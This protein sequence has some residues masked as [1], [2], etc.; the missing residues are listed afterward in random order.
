MYAIETQKISKQFGKDTIFENIDFRIKE[1]EVISILGPSG[2]GKSTFIRCLANLE[3]I[4][5]GTIKIFDKTLVKDGNYVTTKEQKS[6]LNNVGFVFQELNLFNHLTVE[7]NLKLSPRL[8]KK[9]DCLINQKYKNLLNA[10]GL[11]GKENN[12]PQDLSGGQKQRVAIARALM[13]E[14]SILLFDEPTSALDPK[15]TEETAKIILELASNKKTIIIV[16][17]DIFFSELVSDKTFQIS[18]N[19]FSTLPNNLKIRA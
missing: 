19:R 14:P 2:E 4:Y 9:E 11:N 7:Q 1:G 6:I 3:K 5:K 10:L 17:H 8:Q 16:T 18:E 13:L 12:F 15:L